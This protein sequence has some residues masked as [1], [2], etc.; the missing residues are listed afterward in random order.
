MEISDLGEYSNDYFCERIIFKLLLSI[1]ISIE[2]P[3]EEKKKSS[4]EK[5]GYL[6][7]SSFTYNV[8]SRPG[9]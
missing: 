3:L 4:M 9:I 6:A 2:L 5:S 7:G 8:R 1:K